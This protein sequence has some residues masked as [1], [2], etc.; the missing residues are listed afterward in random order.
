MPRM[1]SSR[2][3]DKRF[4]LTKDALV[5]GL[6]AWMCVSNPAHADVL[7][8]TSG[9][10]F[11]DFTAQ[12]R[13]A[14]MDSVASGQ[15][16][17][18]RLA[19]LADVQAMFAGRVAY[20]NGKASSKYI[21][22]QYQARLGVEGLSYTATFEECT[23]CPTAAVTSPPMSTGSEVPLTD[24]LGAML[25]TPPVN[26]YEAAPQT[27]VT[28]V[29]AM[30]DAGDGAMVPVLFERAQA[31]HGGTCGID[32]RGCDSRFTEV[33]AINPTASPSLGPFPPAWL[34]E[35]G[36]LKT[37]GY[38]MVKPDNADTTAWLQDSVPNEDLV[39]TVLDDGTM[40]R[41]SAYHDMRPIVT[42]VRP[43][44]AT[45]TLTV[46]RID[47]D[48][49]LSAS[50]DPTQA[51]VEPLNWNKRLRVNVSGPANPQRP[52]HARFAIG[53]AGVSPAV[54]TV[55]QAQHL[56]LVLDRHAVTVPSN[57]RCSEPVAIK[58]AWAPVDDGAQKAV[59]TVNTSSVGLAGG[60]YTGI[61][62]WT[63][64]PDKPTLSFTSANWNRAQTICF[65][66]THIAGAPSTPSATALTAL[67]AVIN[68]SAAH[69]NTDSIAI[70]WT[71]PVATPPAPSV[72]AKKPWWRWW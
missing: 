52:L 20:M 21:N 29:A 11:N 43:P 14:R 57:G 41:A 18:Y 8:G 3:T 47:G 2:Y 60:A 25:L 66:A 63:V 1:F 31:S 40:G 22:L 39:W 38:L 49:E 67:T 12:L 16:Q 68:V 48:P 34:N 56:Q 72:K 44:S 62:E 9:Q 59:V 26:L 61:A 46:S 71:P 28:A 6:A 45:R 24:A 51:A 42:L 58:L 65:S 37:R 69:A 10:G 54:L 23:G 30:A 70:S 64:D 50:L 32:P 13:W 27:A 5:C 4:M 53:G 7:A 33:A 15:A 19:T 35:Q 55:R 36:Q 17:G